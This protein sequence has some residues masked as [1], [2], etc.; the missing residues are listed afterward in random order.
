MSAGEGLTVLY[1]QQEIER[2]VQELGAD[3]AQAF[4]EARENEP[5]A[6]PLAAEPPN[7]VNRE[8]KK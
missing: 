1:G 8:L 2:K 7:A 4:P 5:S 6:A 3:I